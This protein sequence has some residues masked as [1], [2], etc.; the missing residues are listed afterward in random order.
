MGRA[1][2]YLFRIVVLGAIA[3]AAYAFFADHDHFLRNM[4]P[5]TREI[6]EDLPIPDTR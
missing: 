3:L 1:L 6:V 4:P 2:K 5:P